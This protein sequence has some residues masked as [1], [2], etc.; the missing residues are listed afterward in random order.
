MTWNGTRQLVYRV[1]DPEVIH[2]YLQDVIETKAH[3]RGFDY[4]IEP[5]PNWELSSWYFDVVFKT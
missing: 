4:R 3:P 1:H 5:D 2:S